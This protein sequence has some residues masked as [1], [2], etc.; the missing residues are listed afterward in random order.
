MRCGAGVAEMCQSQQLRA[1]FSAAQAEGR[2][3]QSGRAGHARC[4][5]TLVR[6]CCEQSR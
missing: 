6:R 1:A 4:G 2:W 5:V 3:A